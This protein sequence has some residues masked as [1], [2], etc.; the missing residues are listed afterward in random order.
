MPRSSAPSPLLTRVQA[1]VHAS[2]T[3]EALSSPNLKNKDTDEQTKQATEE[4]ILKLNIIQANNF[5]MM[6]PGK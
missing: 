6:D 5:Y 3:Q 4:K 1:H 2:S